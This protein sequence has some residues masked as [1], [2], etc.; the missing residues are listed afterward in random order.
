ML[1][2]KYN[3]ENALKLSRLL[4][5]LQRQVMEQLSL[6]P[7]SSLQLGC[8]CYYLSLEVIY[9]CCQVNYFQGKQFS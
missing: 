8:F 7:Q 2:Y 3:D 6:L 5:S 9:F 1:K 4:S